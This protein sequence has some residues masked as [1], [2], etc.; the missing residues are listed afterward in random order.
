[1]VCG[2][3]LLKVLRACFGKKLVNQRCAIHKSRN[4]QR[5]LAKSYRSEAHR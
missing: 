1:M 5:R 2:R 3:G 4:L